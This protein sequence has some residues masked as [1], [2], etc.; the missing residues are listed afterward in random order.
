MARIPSAFAYFMFSRKYNWSFSAKP[1]ASIRGG[2]PLFVPRGKAVGGS[3]V[4]NAMVYIRGQREDYDEWEKAGNPGW[5]Y[6]DL[7]PYFKKAE[8]NEN[9]A[10]EFHGDSGPLHVSDATHAYPISNVFLRAANQAGHQS[11]RDFNGRTQEGVGTW[12]CTTKNGERCSS[13]NAYLDPVRKRT[14]LTIVSEALVERIILKDNIAVGVA[15]RQGNERIR[16]E[17][18]REVILSAGAINSPQL[19]MLSGIGDKQ[20][21]DKHGIDCKHHLPGVGKNLQEHVDACVLVESRKSDGLT[22]SLTGL[23][24]LVPSVAN[25]LLRR[26]GR[27]R[28]VVIESGGFIKSRPDIDRPDIQLGLVPLLFDDCGRDLKLMKKNGYSCHVGVLRPK[29]SGNV[30]LNSASPDDAPAID[31]NFFS[32]PDDRQ[33]I[34]DGIK[35]ARKIMAAAAFDEYRGEEI[36]PGAG[37]TTDEAIFSKCKE[38]LGT[39]FHPVGTCKMGQDGMAVVNHRLQLHGIQRLRVVDASIMPNIISGNTNATTVAIAEY[40]SDMILADAG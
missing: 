15:L 2:N 4:T 10:N 17:A 14:N 3:S 8:C 35:Q 25:Y 19:L 37:A 24:R 7:L 38:R 27:L 12:Q 28:S 13:A 34:V 31:F 18:S 30:T 9:G 5:S 26:K 39:V 22:T 29:S 40:A 21:L 36:H 20:E 16:Y 11:N 23:L 33:V 6:N 32:H 1:D